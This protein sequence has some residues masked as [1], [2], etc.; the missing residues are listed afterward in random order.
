MA[1]SN[2]FIKIKTPY[3]IP[4]LNVNEFYNLE[5][6]RNEFGIG[7]L[8]VDLPLKEFM[9]E[10]IATE[11]R[12][13]VYRRTA[14]GELVRVGDTQWIVKL[15]RYKADEQNETLLHIV[16]YD[17]MYILDKRIVAYVDGTPY[18]SKT[19]HADDMLKSIVRENLGE[20]A[21]DYHRDLSNW[22]VVEQDTSSAPIV[23]KSE[24]GMQKVLPLLNDICQLSNAAGVYLSYDVV[25]DESI[26]KLVF[27]TYTHQ[28]GADRGSNSSSP[29][30]L[31]HH[32]DPVNVMGSGL[33]YASI[34]TDALDERSYIYSGRQAE[35]VNAIFAEI[36]NSITLD[37]GPFARSE[38]FITTGESVEYNDV[39]T[40]AHAWLQE[41]FRNLLLNA[42]IQETNDMRFGVDYGFGDI[43]A[44]RYLGTTLDIH[45]DGLKISVDGKGKEEISITASN[46][47][48]ELLI[49]PL[50]GLDDEPL[51]K[52]EPLE[53]DESR[54]APLFYKHHTIAQSFKLHDQP[55]FSGWIP[56]DYVKVMMRRSGLPERNVSMR[57]RDSN[58]AGGMPGT[59]VAY[60]EPKAYSTFADGLYTWA[61]FELSPSTHLLSDHVYW[62]TLTCGIS[63]ESDT[64]YYLVG[65]DPET[66]YPDGVLRVSED[67][68]TFTQYT[69]YAPSDKGWES[70]NAD[71]PF[72]TY[73]NAILSYHPEM[74]GTA[75]LDHT[76]TIIVQQA[77][78]P[79]SEVTNLK[80]NFKR[81]GLPD[82]INVNICEW[83]RKN[84]QVGDSIASA[85]VEALDVSTSV[86]DWY[87]FQF[88]EP[89]SFIAGKLYGIKISSGNLSA[90]N[91]YQI[92]VDTSSGYTP[93]VAYKW[94]EENW[95]DANVDIPFR[96]YKNQLVAY[97][98]T[99]NATANLND[100]TTELVQTVDIP[101]SQI[102][103]LKLRMKRFGRPGDIQV[104][105]CEWDAVN[106]EP[107][108][109]LVTKSIASLDVT[110][111]AFNFYDFQFYEP[112]TISAAGT[113]CI[114][115]RSSNLSSSNYYQIAVD[116]TNSYTAGAGYKL[117]GE[118]YISLGSDLYFMVYKLV[119]HILF[120]TYD[121]TVLDIGKDNDG[122]LQTFTVNSTTQLFKAGVFLAKTGDPQEDITISICEIENGVPTDV[123]DSFT[124]HHNLVSTTTYEWHEDYL[125]G[126]T[127][128][129]GHTYCIR[130]SYN[131]DDN[132]Y[133][134]A[135]VDATKSY[136][137]GIGMKDIKEE[138]VPL[139]ADIAFMIYKL[140]LG[141]YYTVTD[142]NGLDL[143][144][145][146]GGLLQ[147]FKVPT[148]SQLFRAC[149]QVAKVGEPSD[150]NVSIYKMGDDGPEV[151]VSGFTID[152]R[153]VGPTY[154]W[155]EDNL[156]GAIL[157]RAETY[158]IRFSCD[159]D[160]NN[161]YVFRYDSNMGYANGMAMVDRVEAMFADSDMLF[162]IGRKL[163]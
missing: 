6:F 64:D 77:W 20:L 81:V 76:S 21:T 34:E 120:E 31:A 128:V 108:A 114:V 83:D 60:A 155:Y 98:N 22:L 135:R 66:R 4:V 149:I 39:M 3:N 85:R 113:Y 96:T 132:N 122:I 13:E 33:N 95:K 58:G 62:L 92:S 161:Y 139:G 91:Y 124:V 90:S 8:Y 157:Y 73:K 17:A 154:E 35:E 15:V 55:E 71:V 78:I 119:A 12:I 109:T 53:D 14:G 162:R 89:V 158:C 10:N 61:R 159:E 5:L 74:N 118:S 48:K 100:T 105:L 23:T 97:N 88:S 36:G 146:N 111:S 117:V 57:I 30:Y 59:V 40:E 38:D 93:G 130:M 68:K 51:V 27:K 45:L 41:K 150:L 24:F 102:T 163:P 123:I 11:W 134:N 79:V 80:L 65:V 84:Q 19:M 129:Y 116:S 156:N 141:V 131:G 32:T 70:A 44:L 52:N 107:G 144:K 50:T 142:T 86:F 148:D 28:R 138:Y 47:E 54:G 37:S 143:G 82:D 2:Y 106:V 72:K 103:N 151:Q 9:I 26:G 125:N 56:V 42:H 112:E 18:T 49:S 16:A 136:T 153:R 69:E 29:V 99:Y 147:T 7:S 160:E 152:H 101:I 110:S 43:L 94:L 126:G 121:T 133:Y 140:T 67:G 25:Y 87:D 145:T 127:L 115:I 1:S 63:K 75:N 104:A 46:T 137:G